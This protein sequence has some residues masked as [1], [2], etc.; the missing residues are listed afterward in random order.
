MQK[1]TLLTVGR[2]KALWIGEGCSEY[3]TRLRASVKITV[4][5]IP[6]SRHKDSEKQREEESEQILHALEKERG[7]VFLL[8]EN[9]ERM[10]SKQF[11][12]FLSKAEDMGIPLTFIIGGAYGV[13]DQVRRMVRGSIQLSDMT[14][15]HEMSRLL[16]LEQLYRASEIR[17]GSAYHH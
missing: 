5:E 10:T 4:I 14:F 8:D 3:I 12:I 2:I 17:K 6:P 1:I 16:F 11:S 9:G 15:T 7:D 13:T